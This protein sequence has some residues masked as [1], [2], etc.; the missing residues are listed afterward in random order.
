MFPSPLPSSS[1]PAVP[2]PASLFLPLLALS[3]RASPD[4]SRML[5]EAIPALR[6]GGSQCK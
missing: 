3:L 2:H 6:G 4:F 5:E 1:W